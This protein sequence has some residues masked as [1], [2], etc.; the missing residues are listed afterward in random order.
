MTI[1]LNCCGFLNQSGYSQAYLNYLLSFYK[2]G[3]YDIKITPFGEKRP[4]RPAIS[5]EKYELFM[6]MIKKGE[7]E[8]RILTYHCIPTMQRRIKRT[9]KVI[10]FVT[11]ETFS[12]PGKWIEILNKS[13]AIVV[14][15]QFNYKI[16]SHEKITKPL[17]YIPH[18]IDLELYN[19]NIKP[20]NKYD[21]YTFCYIGQLRERKGYIQL[22]ESF[23]R[24][25]DDK[26]NVQ[27]LIKTDKH[28]R[29][30][31][32]IE[33]LK[34][35]IGIN[36]GFAPI[37]FENK[38]LDEKSL[39]KFI[40]S[41]DC[42]VAPSL[43]EGFFYPGL[44]CMALKIPIIIT[45]FSGCQDY[46]NET[47]ATLLE[48][49]GFIFKSNMD[50]VPQFKNKKWAFI[51]VKKIQKAMRYVLNN[52]KEVKIK[53]DNGYE[54]VRKKFNYKKISNLFIEMIKEIYD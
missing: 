25:F 34:R 1:K 49:N 32:H 43:G 23:L 5:D 27:L 3:L 20:L 13:D 28:K 4:S 47:T 33:K 31:E 46:A 2:T 40:K 50:N 37:I 53:V 15:S 52:E 54:E 19:E 9:K 48:S 41:I 38:V 39:P 6:S 22:F 51:E 8:D 26:D 18:C 16:F 21:R 24:E 10:S 36:K 14:P 11:F 12:P 42:L 17:H 29:A 30:V 44:Q 45:N 35:Q 7:D